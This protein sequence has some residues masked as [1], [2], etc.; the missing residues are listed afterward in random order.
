MC[1][2]SAAFIVGVVVTGWFPSYGQQGGAFAG[3]GYRSPLPLGVAPGQVVTL[4][5]SGPNTTDAIFADRVPLPTNLGGFIV[6]A[7]PGPLPVPIFSVL[8]LGGCSNFSATVC[9][10]LTGVTVQIPFEVRPNIPGTL[11]TPTSFQLQVS[12]DGVLVAVADIAPVFDL[13]HVITSCDI[14][15][16]PSV[17]A[18]TPAVTHADGGLVSE[19]RPAHSEEVL[20]LYAVG[21]GTPTAPVKAGQP[22]PTPP[23]TAPVNIGFDFHPNALASQPIA[24]SST[25]S[26]PPVPIFSGLTPGSV[27]LY[28][29][30]FRVPA[31]PT[32]TVSCGGPVR[33]NLT[34]SIGG[35]ASFDGAGICVS[36]VGGM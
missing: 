15:Q 9:T 28:Q 13:I 25:G 27:G 32:G 36:T 34:V 30:N 23:P 21:L 6:T 10:R 12:K 29:V 1:G 22:T 4:Y 18:C 31:P 35:Q 19:E 11:V 20:V 33:S 24:V 16:I 17:V 3:A 2:R 5:I 7:L 26:P 14:T 8:P